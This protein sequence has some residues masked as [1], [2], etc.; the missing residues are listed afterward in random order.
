[1]SIFL[2]KILFLSFL[3]MGV[4]PIS[5]THAVTVLS[6]TG[7]ETLFAGLP[8]EVRWA[9]S[10]EEVIFELKYSIDGGTKWKK[11]IKGVSGTSYMWTIPVLKANYHDCRIMVI[12]YNS[13]KKKINE[14]TSSL[15][16]AID[17]VRIT[18]PVNE[19]ELMPGNRHTVTW[20]TTPAL[21][22]VGQVLLKYSLTNG[23][24]WT[25]IAAIPGNPGSFDWDVP[26]LGGAFAD[27]KVMAEVR[28]ERGKKVGQYSSEG[29]FFLGFTAKSYSDQIVA[30]LGEDPGFDAVALAI[31]KGYSVPQIM[32]ASVNSRLGL[33]GV[34]TD[35]SGKVVKP[36]NPPT[37]YL[38]TPGSTRG[39]FVRVG[40]P[41][42]TRVMDF[43]EICKTVGG[44]VNKGAVEL[45][46]GLS[47]RGYTLDQIITAI[48]A[49]EVCLFSALCKNW[50]R[51]SWHSQNSCDVGWHWEISISQFDAD[52]C[53]MQGTISFHA[54]PGGGRANYFFWGKSDFNVWALSLCEYIEVWDYICNCYERQL[55]IIEP[56]GKTREELLMQKRQEVQSQKQW[57][58][59][60]LGE[61]APEHQTFY[62]QEGQP[63][64]PN[65]AP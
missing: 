19:D 64:K 8:L 6:P 54:C 49:D 32:E 65:F 48:M 27:C 13:S 55:N 4:F 43:R 33:E 10:A 44:S 56:K 53:D 18:S 11:I 31:D 2:K 38:E 15:P 7:G 1:M 61:N 36:E 37:N 42:K 35:A 63:P 28:D 59:G 14:G 30:D 21:T 41:G 47:A 22:S 52:T 26:W 3:V 45:I 40:A 17:V 5:T 60:D 62:L 58:A 46:I 16:F 20:T 23:K 57:G 51:S 50:E 24:K 12:G 34:I 29:A 25:N 39:A 9:P